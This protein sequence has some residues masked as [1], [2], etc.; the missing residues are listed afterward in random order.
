MP[1]PKL[2]D[3]LFIEPPNDEDVIYGDYN[4]TMDGSSSGSRPY[5]RLTTSLRNITRNSGTD[6]R[7]RCDAIGTPPISFEWKKNHAPVEKSKRVRIRNRENTSRLVISSLDVLDS[8]FYECTASNI[9]GSVNSTAILK[10]KNGPSSERVKNRPSTSRGD[11]NEEDYDDYEQDMEDPRGRLPS[12]EDSDLYTVPDHA[13]GPGFM[14]AGPSERWLDDV[15]IKEGQCVLYRGEACRGFLAGRHIRITTKNRED[16][17]D[18][19]R[20]LRAAVMFINNFDRVKPE[21]KRI[22]HAVACFHMYKVCDPVDDTR[23]QTICKEDC[24]QLTLETCPS[25]M[26]EAGAHDLIGDSPRALFP[27][28]SALPPSTNCIP[29]L[30][31]P[32]VSPEGPSRPR[33]DH[34]CYSESGVNYQGMVSVTQSGK[35]CMDWSATST[36][37][38]SPHSYPHLRQSKNYCRNPGGRRPRPWCYSSPLGQEEF[39]DI[40]MCPPNLVNQYGDNTAIA[41]NSTGV[42]ALWLGLGTSLQLAVLGGVAG[43]SLLFL[44]CLLFCCCKGK[45]ERGQKDAV[46]SLPPP[47]LPNIHSVPHST[48]NTAYYHK[49][50]GTST[51][52][53][54]RGVEMSSLLSGPSRMG[55]GGVYDESMNT[56]FH[57]L[58]IAPSSIIRE[59]NIGQSPMGILLIGGTWRGS[60]TGDIP[61]VAKVARGVASRGILEDEVRRVAALSHPNLLCLFGVSFRDSDTMEVI[62]EY[63]VNGTL[64]SLC[65]VRADAIDERER[66]NNMVDFLSAA[67]QISSG[68]EYLA[69]KM[70]VHRDVAARNVVVGE[71][72]QVKVTDVASMMEQYREDYVNMVGR[73]GQPIRWMPRESIEAGRFTQKSDVWAFGV[74]LWEMYSYGRQPYDGYSDSQ[75]QQLLSTRQ[76]LESPPHCPTNMYSLMVECWHESP[77]RR[78]SFS[79]INRR[80]QQ[81]G[82]MSPAPR[83]TSSSSQSGSSRGGT[84]A[85]RSRAPAPLYPQ[86]GMKRPEDASPLMGMRP[87]YVHEEYSDEDRDSD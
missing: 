55:D 79:E 15:K 51:P 77:D 5:L 42:S 2:D 59:H 80:L 68:L 54:G 52:M 1:L 45:G 37:E 62:Y 25:E 57:V 10:V 29:I 63:A 28:C 47:S 65:R 30:K 8:A 34:W 49:M 43:L 60:P 50:N 17:Y 46:S 13:A 31:T 33:P 75:V 48:I 72:F 81:W 20:N 85:G 78:P 67:I 14:S 23:T 64:H 53:G 32:S 86:R 12:E 11:H 24:N 38:F 22:S 83:G 19:D 44:C 84:M 82:S 73:S 41:G 74:T 87:Q 6:V 40:P 58:E 26:A 71:N 76:L 16:M 69:V 36:R 21:C 56:P 4:D 9:A 27:T 61:I 18:V 70:L 35:E 39:C 3:D 7:L 66:E